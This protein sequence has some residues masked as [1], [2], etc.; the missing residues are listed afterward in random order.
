LVG[1]GYGLRSG[2]GVGDVFNVSIAKR[3]LLDITFFFVVNVGMLN[4]VGGVIIT[5]FGQ[6]RENKMRR[7]EDTLNVCFICSIDKQVFDRA[8]DEPDGFQTHIKVDHNMWNYLYYIFL[9]WEQDRD[10]DDGL[11][12]FVRRAIDANEIIWFPTNKA[13]RLN[14]AATKE[15]SLIND[16]KG[17][18]SKTK[19]NIAGKLD[20]FQTDINIILEQLNQTLKQDHTAATGGGGGGT[21]GNPPQFQ[22][23]GAHTAGS[24]VVSGSVEGLVGTSANPTARSTGSAKDRSRR[25]SGAESVRSLAA[26]AKGLML[27]V[28]DIKGLESLPSGVENVFCTIS[29]DELVHTIHT[30]Q[31]EG[32]LITFP[33]ENICHLVEEIDVF[34]ERSVKLQVLY[35]D[36]VSDDVVELIATTISIEELLLADGT[37]VEILFD[38]WKFSD[39]GKI[40]FIPTIVTK[41]K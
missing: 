19:T 27:K 8:S 9:L 40:S 33:R 28:L 17:K 24:S 4:L 1:L 22:L 12:Q 16:I 7:T 35:G 36:P 26:V 21:A 32:A 2:G 6:L 41:V 14:Q 31:I 23:N 13:I 3:W 15:E 37:R 5:T 25:S 34:D 38:P 11:E 29:L 18:V 39:A 30:N 10:D 20:R